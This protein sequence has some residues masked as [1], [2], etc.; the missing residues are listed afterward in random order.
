MGTLIKASHIWRDDY[1]A[2]PLNSQKVT[3]WCTLW[4]EG[5]TYHTANE[6]NN[7]LKETFSE[8]I[9]SRRG[10]VPWSP[11]SC[12]LTALDCFYRVM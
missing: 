6:T 3:A 8:R 12:D 9:I 5:H 4:V 10:P 1:F 2:T 11:I 7:V